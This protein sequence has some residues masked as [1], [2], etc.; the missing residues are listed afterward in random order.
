MYA[1]LVEPAFGRTR[2]E[3]RSQLAEAGIETRRAFIPVHLQPIYRAAHRGR[4]YPVAESL[5][6][7]G[8]YLPTSATLSETDVARVVAAV[9]AARQPARA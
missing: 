7:R 4:S 1:L 2:D 6:A 9:R 8:L 3:L 5:C